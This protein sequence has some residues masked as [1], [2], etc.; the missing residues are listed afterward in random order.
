[1]YL[2]KYTQDACIV[3]ISGP[4]C[5]SQNPLFFAVSVQR[6]AMF[7]PKLMLITECVCRIFQNLDR[8]VVS[9]HVSRN[10]ILTLTR[11]CITKQINWQI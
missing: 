9:Q 11:R 5:L 1:M 3:C 10:S 7:K 4:L 6:W 2:R 8:A